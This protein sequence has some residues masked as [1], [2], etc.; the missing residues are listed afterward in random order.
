MRLSELSPNFIK[1]MKIL[2]MNRCIIAAAVLLLVAPGAQADSLEL[3]EKSGDSPRL[4]L[5]IRDESPGKIAIIARHGTIEDKTVL[6]C[7]GGV[8]GL[9]T[10]LLEGLGA[11][12]PKMPKALPLRNQADSERKPGPASLILRDPESG[13]DLELSAHAGHAQLLT[14]LAANDKLRV[15]LSKLTDWLAKDLRLADEPGPGKEELQR[16]R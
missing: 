4:Q 6:S 16:L 9:K 15:E 7:E 13:V 10:R 3:S 8:P 5:S 12:L 2:L 14:I 1:G 11:L